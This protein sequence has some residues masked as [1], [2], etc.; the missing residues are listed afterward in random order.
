MTT[1]LAIEDE[2][3]IELALRMLFEREGYDFTAAADGRSGLRQLYRERPD[4]VVLDVGLPETT[5]WTVLER[6]RDIS[7]I[8]VLM[9]T[10]HSQ[11]SDKVRGL[12][13]GADDYLTKPFARNELLARVEALLRRTGA[14]KAD[15][16]A[17]LDWDE[18]YDDGTVRIDPRTREVE[19]DGSQVELTNT[20][21]RLFNTLVRHAGAVLSARQLLERV[22]DDPTGLGPERV[23]FAVLR[24]RRKLGWSSDDSPIKAVRGVGYRYLRWR[25]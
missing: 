9:L 25:E 2:P 18:P 23:K 16:T 21:F 12:R 13:A 10:A 24:L 8:P 20:E 7:E 4:P 1:I 15:T 14:S 11:E 17:A 22:W 6:I 5:G 3:D 19:V